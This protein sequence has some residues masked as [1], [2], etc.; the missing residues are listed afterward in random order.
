MTS[1]SQDFECY[2]ERP[3]AMA[4]P[5]FTL[6]AL[7]ASFIANFCAV[8]PRRTEVLSVH[9]RTADSVAFFAVQ[10][11]IL[12]RMMDILEQVGMALAFPSQTRW[13]IWVSNVSLR[14]L[15]QVPFDL[16]SVERNR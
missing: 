5:T 6:M 12:F 9:V 16:L 8:G 2:L 14:C 11:D 1:Q 15:L 13:P 10:E 4:L 7:S 3:H